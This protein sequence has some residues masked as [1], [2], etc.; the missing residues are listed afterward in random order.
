[1]WYERFRIHDRGLVRASD[2]AAA[3]ICIILLWNHLAKFA[4]EYEYFWETYENQGSNFNMLIKIK[5]D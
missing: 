5:Y 3:K 2:Q 4:S 1:M